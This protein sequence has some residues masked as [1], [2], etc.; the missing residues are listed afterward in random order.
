MQSDSG[1]A[2]PRGK[3]F[4]CND[5]EVFVV[6]GRTCVLNNQWG[7]RTPEAAA[8]DR[9]EPHKLRRATSMTHTIARNVIA[10]NVRGHPDWQADASSRHI[11]PI[12]GFSLRQVG[13]RLCAAVDFQTKAIAVAIAAGRK[14]AAACKIRR[15]TK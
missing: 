8:M 2:L 4:F 7:R 10:F 15:E 9:I 3:R 11:S 5:G 12:F 6:D 1:S 13:E 14:F